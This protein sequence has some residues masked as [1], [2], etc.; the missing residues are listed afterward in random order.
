MAEDVIA[1]SMQSRVDAMFQKDKLWAWG[2]VVVLWITLAF[3][4]FATIG[5]VEDGSVKVVIGIAALVL[6]GLNTASIGAMVNHY[7]HDKQFIYE[8]D[9]KHLDAMKEGGGH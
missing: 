7:A 3:V 5:Y 2:F 4:Y 9:I 1:Q 8:L 6:G